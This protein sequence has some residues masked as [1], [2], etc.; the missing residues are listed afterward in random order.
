MT[1]HLLAA[2]I[3]GKGNDIGFTGI[4]AGTGGRFLTNL[5]NTA[6][7]WA[8]IIAVVVIVIAG[9]IYVTSQGEPSKVAQA[10]NAI[11]GSVIGLVV[12]ALAFVITNFV[13]GAFG[14]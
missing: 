8:G 3:D 9:F 5:L 2:L 6:Y 7:F 10:K 4:G 11:L 1:T 13:V 14:K 12:I